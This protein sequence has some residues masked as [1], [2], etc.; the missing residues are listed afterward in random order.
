[1]GFRVPQGAVSVYALY[2]RLGFKA[3]L[4]AVERSLGPLGEWNPALYLVPLVFRSLYRLRC[5]GS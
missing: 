1:M 5:L 4:N 3:G 2:R